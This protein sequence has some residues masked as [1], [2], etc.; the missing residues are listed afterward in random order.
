MNLI[1]APLGAIVFLATLG[2]FAVSPPAV[3]P[4]AVLAA[5]PVVSAAAPELCKARSSVVGS[6]S[7]G[8]VSNHLSGVV[9]FA[10]RNAWAVGAATDAVGNPPMLVSSALVVHWNGA[11]W[12]PVVSPMLAGGAALASITALSPDNM[13][14]VGHQGSSAAG[15]PLVEHWNGSQWSVVPSPVVDQG[16]LLGV[17]GGRADDIWAVGIRLGV[18][19]YTLIEHWNGAVWKVVPSPNPSVD[20]NEIDSVTVTSQDSAWAVGFSLVNNVSVPIITRWDGSRWKVVKAPSTAFANSLLRGVAAAS[21]RD[22]WAVGQSRSDDGSQVQTL[23]EH[24]NG[25][26]WTVVASPSPVSQSWLTGVAVSGGHVWAAGVRVDGFTNHTLVLHGG[27][28]SLSAVSSP[29]R[30][31]DS[32]SLEAIAATPDGG[33]W[34]VGGDQGVNNGESL[35]LSMCSR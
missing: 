8:Q 34:A 14:A 17:S 29:N 26:R 21:E 22:V 15:T 30:G 7:P 12:S 6:P 3:L 4:P 11:A 33:A 18:T 13:W 5:A 32:N 27:E 31:L 24:W 19:S 10:A 35:V 16:Y 9:S 23:V 28:G 1:T 25:Q 20:Y 2:T